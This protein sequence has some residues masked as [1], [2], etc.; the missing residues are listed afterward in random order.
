[1]EMLYGHWAGAAIT[2]LVLWSTLASVF[3][4]LLGY[5]RVPYAAATEGFF[6][7]QFARLHPTGGFPH[8]SLLTIGALS[9]ACAML[10]LES[11]LSALLTAR[12]LR[13]SWFRSAHCTICGFAGPISAGRFRPG[14]TRH[15]RRSH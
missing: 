2:V 14:C 4:L 9:A 5:S 3:A 13:S 15:R 1:M 11:V 8:V 12:I 10:N 6:F 7:K